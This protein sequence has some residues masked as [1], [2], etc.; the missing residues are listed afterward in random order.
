MAVLRVAVETEL[1]EM[2]KKDNKEVIEE[3]GGEKNT[4]F[5][6]DELYQAFIK[7]TGG[8]VTLRHPESGYPTLADVT[9]VK[10]TYA[11]YKSSQELRKTIKQ[12]DKSSTRLTRWMLGLT[13]LIAVLTIIMLFLVGNHVKL[14]R[15]QETSQTKNNLSTTQ[16]VGE[17]IKNNVDLKKK[18]GGEVNGEEERK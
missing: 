12:F 7:R 9:N 5:D 3:S 14:M 10:L 15:R 18:K 1:R 13:A 16:D 2:A 4:E 8:S 17:Q 11:N 6:V